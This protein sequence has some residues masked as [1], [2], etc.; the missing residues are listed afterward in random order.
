MG[1]TNFSMQ[2][3][4]R[5]RQSRITYIDSIA[6]HVNNNTGK[7][8]ANLKPARQVLGRIDILVCMRRLEHRRFQMSS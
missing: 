6:I 5:K 2:V 1:V 8:N 3:N 7:G 4:N